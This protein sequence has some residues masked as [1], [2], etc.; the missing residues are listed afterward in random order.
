MKEMLFFFIS[1]FN[2][3]YELSISK[4]KFC[5]KYNKIINYLIT[6]MQRI[7]YLINVYPIKI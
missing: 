3:I 1:V 2:F 7:F 6:I 4:Y 5:Q